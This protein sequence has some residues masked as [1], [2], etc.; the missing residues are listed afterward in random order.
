MTE[1]VGKNR[2]LARWQS[3]QGSRITLLQMSYPPLQPE[4]Q[5]LLTS[6]F[7]SG[8]AIRSRRVS[9]IAL[10]GTVDVPV[11]PARLLADGG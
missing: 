1:R 8:D 3:Y 9:D 5:N 4:S 11:P 7:W 10:S 2:S 6:Y